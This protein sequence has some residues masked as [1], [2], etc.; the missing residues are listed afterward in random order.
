MRPTKTVDNFYDQISQVRMMVIDFAMRRRFPTTGFPQPI[1]RSHGP[2]VR[3]ANGEVQDVSFGEIDT[4][5]NA[6]RRDS[7]DRSADDGSGSDFAEELGDLVT[8]ICDNLERL[9]DGLHV[10]DPRHQLVTST[11]HV[12]QAT[13]ALATSSKRLRAGRTARA[14]RAQINLPDRTGYVG[15]KVASETSQVVNGNSVKWLAPLSERGTKA[16]ELHRTVSNKGALTSLYFTPRQ[17]T[18]LYL[19]AEGR[20]TKDIAR[21]LGL[22]PGTVKIHLGAIYRVIHARSRLEAV[23]KARDLCDRG[24]LDPHEVAAAASLLKARDGNRNGRGN[25]PPSDEPAP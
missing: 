14:N 22:G 5:E 12:A 23:V 4:L 1:L 9:R 15:D 7:V 8:I 25:P 18:V 20:S 2:F 13:S 11:L 21:Q 3:D 6:R 10:D 19:L 24:F 17:V 16:L